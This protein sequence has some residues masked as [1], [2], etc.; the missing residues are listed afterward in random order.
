[1]MSFVKDDAI[2]PHPF[3]TNDKGKLTDFFNPAYDTWIQQEQLVLSWINSC[4]NSTL[5]ATVARLTSAHS[6][7]VALEKCFASLNQ[8]LILQLRSE[9]FRTTRGDS[10]IA[11]YL[12]K[13]NVITDN[14]ALSGSP[15]LGSDLLAV[16]MN[17][18]GPLYKS[19]VASAQAH[20]TPITYANLEALL[21][22][23]EQHHL[24]V[25]AFACDGSVDVSSPKDVGVKETDG[26][27][28]HWRLSETGRLSSGG[29]SRRSSKRKVLEQEAQIQC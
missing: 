7:C 13:V 24:A 19:T 5:L 2:A 10:F 1:M 11:D 22:F 3:L 25:Q 27:K 16:I 23:V 26:Q 14:R 20:E 21:L 9:L 18:V 6:T 4:L 12:D 28:R 15:I 17:N 29:L 8:N